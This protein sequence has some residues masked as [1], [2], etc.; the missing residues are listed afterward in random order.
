MLRGSSASSS[1]EQVP[2][3]AQTTL[4]NTPTRSSKVHKT[5]QHQ[6]N[7]STG[8]AEN[9][10]ILVRSPPHT[11]SSSSSS[12]SPSLSLLS[13]S[14]GSISTSLYQSPS[15]NIVF[16]TTNINSDVFLSKASQTRIPSQKWSPGT[17]STIVVSLSFRV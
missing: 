11:P 12:S 6:R 13:R 9:V 14:T 16:S 2:I 3:L 15:K 5:F 1:L 7:G 17:L 8:K 4:A 10:L